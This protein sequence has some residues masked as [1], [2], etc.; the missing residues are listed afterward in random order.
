MKYESM[1]K[2]FADIYVCFTCNMAGECECTADDYKQKQLKHV[3][4]LF[5]LYLPLFALLKETNSHFEIRNV[6]KE[7]LLDEKAAAF[8][9][10]LVREEQALQYFDTTTSIIRKK[11]SSKKK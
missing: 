10:N 9:R 3:D 2:S 4:M 8:V 7:L 5:R 1:K 11:L 6:I